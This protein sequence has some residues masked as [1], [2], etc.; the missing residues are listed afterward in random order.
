M[1]QLPTGFA[2]SKYPVTRAEFSVFATETNFSDKGCYQWDDGQWSMAESADWQSP[3]F[4]Q[5]DDHPVVCV[6]WLDATAYADWLTEKTGRSY[7]LP[8]LEEFQEATRAGGDTDYWWG[9]DA[10]AVCSHANV[11]DASLEAVFKNTE[12]HV[13]CDDGF[14]YTSPVSQFPA[15][16]WGLH[17]M[18]GNVWQWT[19]SCLKGDCSNAHFRGGAWN[20]VWP[21]QFMITESFGDRIVVR[22]I[23]LGMRVISEGQSNRAED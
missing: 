9:A 1:V 14:V 18:A 22:S 10:T 4:E 17:D 20:D 7:R 11:G 3:G 12:S 16:E 19:N 6:S 23:G 21:H 8:T 15:N 13:G 2:F 5:G